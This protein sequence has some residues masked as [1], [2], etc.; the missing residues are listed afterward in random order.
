MRYTLDNSKGIIKKRINL[1][2]TSIVVTFNWN[3]TDGHWMMNIPELVSSRRV[4]KGRVLFRNEHGMLWNNE[5]VSKLG[6]DHIEWVND[7]VG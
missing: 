1:I 2:N 4:V 5:D 6:F 7:A 3:S